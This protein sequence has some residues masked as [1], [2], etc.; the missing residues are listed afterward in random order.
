M[1]GVFWFP[2]REKTIK[3]FLGIPISNKLENSESRNLDT[4][5]KVENISKHFIVVFSHFKKFASCEMFAES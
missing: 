1:F 5:Y 2:D 4:S 3:C